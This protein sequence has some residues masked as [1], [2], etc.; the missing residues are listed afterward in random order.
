MV[1]DYIITSGK[2]NFTAKNVISKNFTVSQ[3]GNIRWTGNP[4]N[5]EINLKAIYEVRTD[6]SNLYLAAGSQSPYGNRQ[7]FVQAQLILTKSLLQ[8]NID[9]DFNFPTEPNIKD[10]LAT[11][12]SDVNNRNQQALSIIVRRNFASGT[13]SN[14]TQE[15]RGTAL[16]AVSEFAFNKLNNLI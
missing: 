14:L 5:A 16:S 11:Y 13:G 9:F 10:D 15:V 8:P 6:I 12:L 4:A 3:G 1:G 7:V 2:F